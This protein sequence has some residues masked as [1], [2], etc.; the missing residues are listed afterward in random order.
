MTVPV[1]E[2]D[3]IGG[4]AGFGN[5]DVTITKPSG[6]TSGDLLI[7]HIIAYLGTD[8]TPPSGWAT[9]EEVDYGSSLRGVYYL[10]AGGSEPSEYVWDIT[11]SASDRACGAI[12]RISGADTTTPVNVYGYNQ[13]T[14]D[15]ETDQSPSVTTTVNDCL[16]LLVAGLGYG[17]SSYTVPA[18]STE[19]WFVASGASIVGSV[20]ATDSQASAGATGTKQWSISG[21]FGGG[22]VLWNIAIAPTGGGGGT[23]VFNA[24]WCQNTNKLIPCG[25]C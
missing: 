5:A 9:L 16:L 14:G 7:A 25:V 19:Q 10:I 23:P 21:T 11:V 15:S 3:A 22:F 24:A 12:A 2:S 8:I 18:S 20:G 6:T 13:Y 1:Y 4:A 17:G